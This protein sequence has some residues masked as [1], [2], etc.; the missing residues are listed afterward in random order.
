M[1]IF[2]RRKNA[3]AH[4]GKYGGYVSCFISNKCKI[5]EISELGVRIA[6]ICSHSLGVMA[7]SRKEKKTDSVTIKSFECN[8]KKISNIILLINYFKTL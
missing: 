6:E 2:A 8:K 7:N 5:C 3:T 1:F 4:I